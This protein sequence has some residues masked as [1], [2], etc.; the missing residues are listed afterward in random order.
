S[1]LVTADVAKALNYEIGAAYQ[2]LGDQKAAL[3]YFTRVYRNDPKYRDVAASVEALRNQL[4][5]T[6]LAEVDGGSD[7]AVRP[8]GLQPGAGGDAPAGKS[9]KIGYV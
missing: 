3:T 5:D 2:Q 1:D 4:S 7:A 9:R 8:V 6:D